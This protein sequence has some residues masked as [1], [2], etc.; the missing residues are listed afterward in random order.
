MIKGWHNHSP[1]F[2][3]KKMFRDSDFILEV[4]GQQETIGINE[5]LVE[6]LQSTFLTVHELRS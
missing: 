3:F 2:L 5:K 4:I 6:L 1:T